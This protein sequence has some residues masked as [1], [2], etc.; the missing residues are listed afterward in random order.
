MVWLRETL[1]G[2]YYVELKLLQQ[3]NTDVHWYALRLQMATYVQH[4]PSLFEC[5]YATGVAL[6]TAS[7]TEKSIRVRWRVSQTSPLVYSFT[8]S[9]GRIWTSTYFCICVFVNQFRFQ[10]QSVLCLLSSATDWRV[11]GFLT[12]IRIAED[13]VNSIV[14]CR[15][16]PI[17]LLLWGLAGQIRTSAITL[18]LLHL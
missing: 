8:P 9:S 1:Y 12:E 3:F 17:I 7:Y 11:A 5:V 16:L 13:V 14:V 10:L 6:P 4:R 15:E 18:L 2:L